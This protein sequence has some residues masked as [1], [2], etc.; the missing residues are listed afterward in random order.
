[1]NWLGNLN[2]KSIFC[3][4]NLS[5][6]ITADNLSAN[7]DYI[8]CTSTLTFFV[9]EKGKLCNI[10]EI[11]MFLKMYIHHFRYGTLPEGNTG[12]TGK[13]TKE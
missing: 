13:K 8:S 11:Q 4:I 1:M 6:S 2:D 9:E 7:N 12:E 10:K 5:V 3:N